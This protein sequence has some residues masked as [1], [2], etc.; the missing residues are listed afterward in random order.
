MSDTTRDERLWGIPDAVDMYFD[1]A[2][3]Y[4]AEIDPYADEHDRRPRV[5]EEWT[6]TDPVSHFPAADWITEWIAESAC[7]GITEHGHDAVMDLANHP[8]VL[9]AAEALRQ[10][11]AKHLT[12][13]M[14]DTL[15]AE[16]TVTWDADGNP[17][18]DGERIYGRSGGSD[19]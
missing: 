5:L 8:D 12:Y 7:E 3:A 2:A 9:A 14:A 18:L 4:E 15:V 19:E 13:R 17:L 10:V 6:V 1:A 16:H 11:M